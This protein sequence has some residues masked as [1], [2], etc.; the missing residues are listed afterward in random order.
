[1]HDWKVVHLAR[2]FLHRGGRYPNSHES[3]LSADTA[4]TPC[5]LYP[6]SGSQGHLRISGEGLGLS[7]SV[8]PHTAS[9]VQ[10]RCVA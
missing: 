2:P 1:M 9:S 10:E 6:T 8:L 7:P 3:T 4:R 5:L